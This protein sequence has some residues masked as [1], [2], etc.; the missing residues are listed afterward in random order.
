MQYAENMVNQFV[1]MLL[2]KSFYVQFLFLGR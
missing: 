1:L 2:V